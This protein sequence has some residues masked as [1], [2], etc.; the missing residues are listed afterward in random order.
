MIESLPLLI[1]LTI[2]STGLSFCSHIQH[3]SLPQSLTSGFSQENLRGVWS[4]LSS[5]HLTTSYSFFR[6]WP[7][8]RLL[9]SGKIFLSSVLVSIKTFFKCVSH[10]T[11]YWPE[12]HLGCFSLL[13][14]VFFIQILS[15][16]R[17]GLYPLYSLF[18]FYSTACGCSVLPGE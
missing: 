6:S 7:G 3:P 17:E 11:L 13:D 2:L 15:S 16:W 12:R 1:S 10:S 9:G 5:L 18:N 8:K 4:N 14:C